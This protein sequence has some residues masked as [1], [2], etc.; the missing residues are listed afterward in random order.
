MR[1]AQLAR[2]SPASRLRLAGNTLNIGSAAPYKA[3]IVR[4]EYYE[5]GYPE[6]PVGLD[7][8]LEPEPLA[9]AA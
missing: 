3:T 1:S 8:K 9:E 2:G 5:D 7:R 6:L 4:L